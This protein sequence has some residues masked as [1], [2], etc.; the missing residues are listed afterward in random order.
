MDFL[1]AA[2]ANGPMPASEINRMARE[3]GLTAKAVRSA[4]E[5]LGVKIERDGFGP[6][7]RWLWSLPRGPINALKPHTCP[8]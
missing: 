5:A 3:H 4:R 7:S 2:L 8:I 6:G 1:Q